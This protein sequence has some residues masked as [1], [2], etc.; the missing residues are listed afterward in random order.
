MNRTIII[1]Q[2]LVHNGKLYEAGSELEVSEATYDA[3]SKIDV[4]HRSLE[5]EPVTVRKSRR[6]AA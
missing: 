4:R 5:R 1:E 2:P 3:L 6:S